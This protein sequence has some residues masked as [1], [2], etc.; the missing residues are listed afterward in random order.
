MFGKLRL[1]KGRV[2]E[3][4]RQ[5]YRAHFCAGC[6]SLHRF[7]GRTASVLT[8]Y[9]QTLWV[10][11]AAALAERDGPAVIEQ[12]P[13]TVAPWRS[14][15]VCPLPEPIRTAAATV[16]LGV[17]GAKLE[18]DV[19]D[20]GRWRSRGMAWLF[21]ARIEDALS[22]LGEQGFPVGILRGMPERQA[23]REAGASR[24]DAVAGPSAGLSAALFVHAAR[25]AD[26]MEH[27]P[28]LARFGAALGRAIYWLD[29]LED[30]AED[31]RKG[32]FNPL[33]ACGLSR[34]VAR[35]M[36]LDAVGAAGRA[37]DVLGQAAALG[38]RIAIVQ[39][40]L[41]T[42]ASRICRIDEPL[43]PSARQAGDCDCGACECV[44][45]DADCCACEC[46]GESA[47]AGEGRCSA[48]CGSPGSGER[49]DGTV[50]ICC[51]CDSCCCCVEA[52]E[53]GR[54]RWKKRRKSPS[55]MT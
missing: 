20:E 55:S 8:N 40:I 44:S 3:E 4:Q 41:D 24:P 28:A 50:P 7:G 19:R 26:A 16:D 23:A 14:V 38:S 45:C 47:E 18:D 30:Q 10:V 15:A 37:W 33:E 36:A 48:G 25:I 22:A 43:G 21:G 49:S 2:D 39:G 9:D 1:Q 17:V 27:A 31:A 34:S 32:R 13:C 5:L 52:R 35:S 42:T 11:V 54:R 46:C 6:H 29:A 12:R 51:C 53:A